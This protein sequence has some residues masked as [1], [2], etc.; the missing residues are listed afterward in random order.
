ME[1]LQHVNIDAANGVLS[2]A[3][4]IGTLCGGVFAAWR[5]WGRKWLRR[6]HSERCSML[7]AALL[8]P[9]IAKSLESHSASLAALSAKSTATAEAV[10]SIHSRLDQQDLTLERIQ[11]RIAG[12]WDSDP[13]PQFIC[14][15]D[16]KYADVNQALATLFGVDKR[17][18]LGWGFRNY[19]RD[20]DDDYIAEWRSCFIEHRTF[21]RE[22]LMR[23]ATGDEFGAHVL[24]WPQ[25]DSP[26]ALAWH[27]YITVIR[28]AAAI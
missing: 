19:V 4:A 10:D 14:D 25:P 28:D 26:P 20:P 9:E 12:A 23:K 11:H 22:T 7:E 5:K 8:T 6:R 24:C 1:P 15:L 16:G 18:L 17:A 27:G 3:T 13:V 21:R 2:L